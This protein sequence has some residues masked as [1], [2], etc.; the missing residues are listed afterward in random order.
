MATNQGR[1]PV[2]QDLRPAIA[3][4]ILRN[5]KLGPDERKVALIL[6]QF[7]DERGVIVDA[8][9]NELIDEALSDDQLNEP[10]PLPRNRP[11]RER[12]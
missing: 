7:T 1:N 3:A 8:E 12:K 2:T 10:A 11:R 9:I 4:S 5:P 6:L